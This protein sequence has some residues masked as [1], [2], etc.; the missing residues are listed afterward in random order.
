MRYEV[1]PSALGPMLWRPIRRRFV[2]G[3]ERMLDN[4][5]REIKSRAGNQAQR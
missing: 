1:E 2:R 5:Q 3:C 4:W